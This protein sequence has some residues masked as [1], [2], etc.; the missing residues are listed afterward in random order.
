MNSKLIK[1]LCCIESFTFSK[2]R[3]KTRD[4]LV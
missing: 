4:F 1:V 2:Y 3:I